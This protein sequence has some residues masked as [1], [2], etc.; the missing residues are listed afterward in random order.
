MD[1]GMENLGHSDGI[2]LLH[3]FF[4]LRSI[5]FLSFGKFCNDLVSRSITTYN[6][7]EKGFKVISFLSSLKLSREKRF[8]GIFKLIAIDFPIEEFLYFKIENRIYFESS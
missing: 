4:F 2:Y 8:R 7:N 5:F 1:G 6:D 3:D